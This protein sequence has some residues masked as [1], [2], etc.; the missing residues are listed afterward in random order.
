MTVQG[1]HFH[2]SLHVHTTGA[3]HKDFVYVTGAGYVLYPSSTH[4]QGWLYCT[5][6]GLHNPSCTQKR[7][8]Y[9]TWATPVVYADTA[10]AA[11][12]VYTQTGLYTIL[13]GLRREGLQ[14][15]E[16]VR[17]TGHA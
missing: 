6:V 11:H 10:G 5:Q 3:T 1:R 13:D 12:I 16:G 17:H 8:L 14:T 2:G 9:T 7:V 4:T 15:Q